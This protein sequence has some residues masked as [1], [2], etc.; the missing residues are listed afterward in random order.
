M[1]LYHRHTDPLF[2]QVFIISDSTLVLCHVPLYFKCSTIISIPPKTWT[3][4]GCN[5]YRPFTLTVVIKSLSNW[6]WTIWTSSHPA[7]VTALH[8]TPTQLSRD[9]FHDAVCWLKLSL[10]HH[11]LRQSSNRTLP[12]LHG[13]DTTCYWIVT[14]LDSEAEG[15]AG[16]HLFPLKNHQHQ[17]SQG[18]AL[19]LPVIFNHLP[20]GRTKTTFW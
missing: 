10:Q 14:L 6:C 16:Q 20:C 9:I 18:C 13:P 11:Q 12:G 8:L 2:S 19:S 1:F 5:D 3:N 4:K 7:V 15:K 17:R